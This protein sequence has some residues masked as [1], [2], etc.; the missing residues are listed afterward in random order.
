[1][2]RIA[3]NSL[4]C[5]KRWGV[6]TVAALILVCALFCAVP[7][8]L[9]TDTDITPTEDAGGTGQA[10]EE[11]ETTA[12][13]DT[14]VT[15]DN[16][17][18]P[19]TTAGTVTPSPD[20]TAT[21]SP[22]ATA[23]PVAT[24]KFT[25]ENATIYVLTSNYSLLN[26]VSAYDEL[27]EAVTVTVSDDGGF[28][29]NTLGTYTIKYS[30]NHP[31]TG[32]NYTFSR[33][34]TVVENPAFAQYKIT[35]SGGD[36]YIKM[37]DNSAYFDQSLTAADEQGNAVAIKLKSRGNFDLTEP[38][39]YKVTLY[40]EHP[41][42]G[43]RFT[44]ERTVHV[45]T[46]EEYTAYLN[47][48]NPLYGKSNS[49]YYKYLKY[50]E[51]IYEQLQGKMNELTAQLANRIARIRN[52]L[53]FDEC[54]IVRAVS[55]LQDDSELEETEA[56]LTQ[57]LAQSFSPETS[58]Y[59]ELDTA[60]V[61]NW[62][63]IL[64]V[65]VAMS[66]LDVDDPLD[67]YNL[68]KITFEDMDAIFFDM[69]NVT[70]HIADGELWIVLAPYNAYE[71]ME[72]YAM[73]ETRGAALEELMQPEFQSVFASL[74]GDE[75]FIELSDDAIAE[76]RSAL[77]EGLSVGRESIIVTA[78]S[79]VEKVSYFWGG[80]YN[81]VGWNTSW[82][83]PRL[84]TSLGSKTTG[85]TR[86]YG[87]DCSGFVSWVFI[88]AAGDTSVLSSIGNGS[89]NQWYRS[90]SLGWDEAMP[91]DLVFRRTPS[92]SAINHVGIIVSKEEDGTYMV[93]HCSSA[94]NGVVVTEA[95]SSGFRYARRPVIYDDV[96]AND[97]IT[98]SA[99]SVL[100]KPLAIPT[101][102]E[103]K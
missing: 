93:A 100:S 1:M 48:I 55:N 23:T 44:Y 95:W 53:G 39:T 35:F 36:L 46:E 51:E 25:G 103:V 13:P 28:S 29:I 34:V 61:N 73:D 90:V 75:A 21:P 6:A 62:S 86:A 68:R 2:K 33:S 70:Y 31:R 91:G 57:S 15:P 78:Y 16:T 8:S 89:A 58:Q 43:E 54:H 101:R 64:A 14:T 82:G 19:G 9:A 98:F 38:G 85:K 63:D 49:R 17:V 66:T 102:C 59:E 94:L 52:I 80:K 79:L 12:T 10:T 67:L 88:N 7:R 87:L 45:L 40:A 74:T 84:V 99:S 18:I 42:T 3:I 77:P 76:I 96:V 97:A 20:T 71:M 92:S 41:V 24:V 47:T 50:R 11:P 30:A 5:A 22:T 27:G 26:G 60:S 56:E 69:L 32:Q 65:F 37:G 72:R 81:E 4:F 83:M